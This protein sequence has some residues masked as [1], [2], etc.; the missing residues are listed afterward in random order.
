MW[1]ALVV[2]AITGILLIIA[3]P[4]RSLPNTAFQIKMIMLIG[5]IGVSFF[6][7]RAVVKTDAD[8]ARSGPLGTTATAKSTGL[9]ILIAWIG[10]VVAGRWIAY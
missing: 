4:K 9:I 6:I 8:W 5:V 3:E 7:W 1:R 10:I 2:M